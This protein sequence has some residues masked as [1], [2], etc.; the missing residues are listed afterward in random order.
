MA[1]V[2]GSHNLTT[3]VRLRIIRRIV[4]IALVVGAQLGSTKLA[5]GAVRG[6][7]TA[8]TVSIGGTTGWWT[9]RE[10]STVV[11]G[12]TATP[13]TPQTIT[14]TPTSIPPVG[15]PSITG[16]SKPPTRS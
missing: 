7:T 5:I 8:V 6:L 9:P 10:P 11:P 16:E 14:P 1:E 15:T 2:L 3:I 12:G 4:I 13:A